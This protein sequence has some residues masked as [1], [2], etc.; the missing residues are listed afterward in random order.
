MGIFDLR[1]LTWMTNY[2]AGDDGDYTIQLKIS[3]VIGGNAPDGATLREPEHKFNDTELADLFKR[4]SVRPTSSS[5]TFPTS[6]STSTSAARGSMGSS[7]SGGAVRS[8]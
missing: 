3:K 7:I 1:S 8:H 4:R 5:G 2:N 6:S